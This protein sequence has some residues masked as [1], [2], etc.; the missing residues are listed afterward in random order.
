[1]NPGYLEPVLL[2][3]CLCFQTTGVMD[4]KY[5]SKPYTCIIM[6]KH[7]TL[8]DCV[9]LILVYNIHQTGI[10]VFTAYTNVCYL[11]CAKIQIEFDDNMSIVY[12]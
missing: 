10:C 3:A 6:I 5:I 7:N 9:F 8:K 1:M 12:I 11:T 4:N 2:Q